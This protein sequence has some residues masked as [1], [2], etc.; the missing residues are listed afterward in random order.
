M[1]SLFRRPGRLTGLLSALLLCGCGIV[2]SFGQ[3]EAPSA[4]DLEAEGPQELLE[5]GRKAFFANDFPTAEEALEKFIR[6]Y[7]EAEEAKEA[8][9][10]HTPFVA[11]SKV[12]NRKFDE[13][14]EWIDKSLAHSKIEFHL[15]DE[16]T[17]W[18]AICLMTQQEL[19]EAQHAFGAYWSNENH[20][21]FKRY[22]A[23]LMFATLYI[24]QD[25]PAEAADF[26][27]EQIPKFRE[28]APEAASRAVILQLYARL[29]AGQNDKALELIRN[30]FPHLKNMTQMISF[31]TLALQLGSK[32]LEEKDWY[33][34]IACLQRIWTREKLLEHQNGKLQM[35]EDRI[36]TLKQRPNTQS[37][38]FQLNAIQ[39]R[40][41]RELE[42][43]QQ[44]ENFDSALRLRLA[45]AFQGLGRYR[46]AALIMEDML[47]TMDPDPVVESATLAQLQCWMEIE[48]WPKAVAT[49]ERY[50]EV[51]GA[52]ATNLATVLFLKAEA[53]RKQNDFGEA[54][55]AYG[56]VVEKFSESSF[57]P[58]SMFMQGFMYLQQDDNEGALFQFDQLKRNY[59]KADLLDDADYWSGQAM[60]FNKD[61]AE[62]RDHMDGYLERWENPRYKKEA[63]FRIAVNTF[64]LAEYEDSIALLEGFVEHYEGD[65]LCD[66]A[67]LL[68]GDAYLGD[69]DME[70]GF[71][72]YDRVRPEAKR[73]FEEAW[74]KKGKAYKLLEEY[75]TMRTHYEKFTA[76]YPDSNRMPEAVYHVGW[77]YLNADE[78]DKARQMYWKTI[79]EHGN[80][81][82]MY[83]VADLFSALPKVY[84]NGGAEGREELLAELEKT[85]SKADVD[86]ENNLALRA[87]WSK[88][89]LLARTSPEVGR[90]EM[91][92]ASKW[93][94]PK[95]QNPLLTVEC[96]DALL[97]AG[98]ILTAKEMFTNI[99]KWHPRAIQKDRIY[100]GLAKIAEE[101]NEPDE[102]IKYYEK[103]EKEA[104]ASARLGEV[105][106]AKAQLQKKIGKNAEA[107]QT[108][109]SILENEFIS[110]SQKALT[111]YELGESLAGDGEHKKAIVYFERVYVAYGKFS[112]LNAKAYLARGESLEE[113]KLQKQAL[114]T[115][116]EFASREELKRF[117]EAN[118]I[119]QK[120]SRLEKVVPADPVEEGESSEERGEEL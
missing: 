115:Y 46:E 39:R 88:S 11:I 6:D 3:D 91:M 118:E 117:D 87:A 17:F 42:S 24:Q 101:Q 48:R 14:L 55:L 43:F 80:N 37:I 45:T 76:E 25:F 26:L 105:L 15:R 100:A 62:S 73:F 70:E 21:A 44:I 28:K 75:D 92:A 4:P 89:Q 10:I 16:L 102:A 96:A 20:N 112:D 68:L 90:A 65:M 35:I 18:K 94:D 38:V 113:L 104:G 98:N 74:F 120:I 57:A 12:G 107:R 30:E 97:D 69:G 5:R 52:E 7:A 111:L 33:N 56:R 8:V 66:E 114:E 93:V 106:V 34:A 110:A 86:G 95:S 59:P 64:S 116:R 58:K 77:T 99:R 61:Y 29:T 84:K 85:K 83:G 103:F 51:F 36:A 1:S 60:A 31:Q 22:E 41:E 49:A 109:E 9:R 72:A 27:E 13:A 82:E 50:E 53:Y 71:A 81:P 2:V 47:E 63:I 54:Q 67:N 40:V 19:V 78:P 108:L 79:G 32:F 23:L 119:G